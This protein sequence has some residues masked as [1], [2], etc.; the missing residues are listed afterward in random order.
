MPSLEDLD[1]SDEIGDF[2]QEQ[3]ASLEHWEQFYQNK[4]QQVHNPVLLSVI[5]CWSRQ[6][7]TL[8]PDPNAAQRVAARAAKASESKV[9]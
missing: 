7:G 5:Q 8:I 6:V 4:Y 1:V 3:R 9:I 2:D